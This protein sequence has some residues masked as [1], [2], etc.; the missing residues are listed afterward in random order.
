MDTTLRYH[1]HVSPKSLCHS[2][3]PSCPSSIHPIPSLPISSLR[4]WPKT[5]QDG[6]PPNHS[7]TRTAHS[8]SLEVALF[9][10][11]PTSHTH[12][13][14]QVLRSPP[15]L[16]RP[17]PS[18]SL[19]SVS[20]AIFLFLSSQS[21]ITTTHPFASCCHHHRILTLSWGSCADTPGS[22]LESPPCRAP[23]PE[24][25]F[26]ALDNRLAAPPLPARLLR[27]ASVSPWLRRTD[28]PILFRR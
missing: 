17:P 11:S 13:H 6:T 16:P 24:Y 14:A 28:P 18:P 3:V 4:G 7:L 23:L 27:T 12:T 15:P 8:P 10:R 2:S 21:A 20:C 1:T 9:S 25:Q 19:G 5:R 22:H 26:S